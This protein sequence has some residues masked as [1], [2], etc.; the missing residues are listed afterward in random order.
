MVRCRFVPEVRV[1]A[2]QIL[3]AARK[4]EALPKM[5]TLLSKAKEV[6]V[7]LEAVNALSNFGTSDMTVLQGLAGEGNR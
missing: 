4:P 7:R 5:L 6:A 2:L 1:K 3:G